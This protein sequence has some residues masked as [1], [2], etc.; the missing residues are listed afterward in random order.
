M[1]SVSLHYPTESTHMKTPTSFAAKMKFATLH[2][3]AALKVLA[4]VMLDL[5]TAASLF[6]DSAKFSQEIGAYSQQAQDAKVTCENTKARLREV[7]ERHARSEAAK[8]AQAEQ[9]TRFN[10]MAELARQIQE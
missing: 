4:K 9:V 3:D 2:N 10:G 5:E 1:A 8:Q 7:I 6:S